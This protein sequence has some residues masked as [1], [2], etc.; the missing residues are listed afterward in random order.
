M[1]QSQFRQ[2]IIMGFADRSKVDITAEY[3]VPT[4]KIPDPGKPLGIIERLKMGGL[5]IPCFL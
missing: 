3:T 4:K 5:C 1:T 2:S